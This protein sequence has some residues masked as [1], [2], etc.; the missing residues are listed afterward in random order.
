V[1]VGDKVWLSAD[2]YGGRTERLVGVLLRESLPNIV[3]GLEPCA[4]VLWEVQV[5]HQIF[6]VWDYLLEINNENR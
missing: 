2:Y 5:K 3:W 6:K 4:P 1:K